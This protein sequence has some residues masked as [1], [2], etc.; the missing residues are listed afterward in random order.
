MTW[1]KVLT[2]FYH[3]I[4]ARLFTGKGIIKWQQ[5]VYYDNLLHQHLSM[6]LATEGRWTFHAALYIP[7]ALPA[8]QEEK[9]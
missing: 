4:K 7:R 6:Q 3:L 1:R 5:H 2:L 9:N 8:P